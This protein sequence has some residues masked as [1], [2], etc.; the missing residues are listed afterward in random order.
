M[1]MI[2]QIINVDSEDTPV[3]LKVVLKDTF[4]PQEGF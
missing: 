4:S 2:P 3:S 1:Q